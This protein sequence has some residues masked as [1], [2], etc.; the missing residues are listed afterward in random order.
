MTTVFSNMEFMADLD[1]SNFSGVVLLKICLE[2]IKES[3]E[4]LETSCRNFFFK[5]CFWRN[6][7]KG[8]VGKGRSQEGK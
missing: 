1:K 8:N 6:E 2:W 5:F 4:K 3:G 7:R